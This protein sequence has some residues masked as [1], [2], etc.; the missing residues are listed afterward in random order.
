MAKKNENSLVF[1]NGIYKLI[2][3][4]RKGDLYTLQLE[5]PTSKF[6]KNQ[7]LI[8]QEAEVVASIEAKQANIN[9]NT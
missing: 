6:Y 2:D 8:E 9:L 7:K 3:H 5:N 4:Q 1:M